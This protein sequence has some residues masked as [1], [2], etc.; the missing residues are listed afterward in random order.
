MHSM[1]RGLL[2][3]ALLSVA[4][5]MP[6]AGDAQV[7]DTVTVR[8]HDHDMALFISGSADDVVVLEA[9]GGSSHRV[10][11]GVVPGLSAFAR[12][13]AYDR[14]GYGLSAACDSPRTA[15]RIVREL[16]EALRAAG[17]PGPYLLAGW[18]LGGSIVRVFAGNFPEEVRGLVL[19]DPAPED[20]YARAAGAY[21]DMWSAEE[22][23]YVPA[24]FAD[25]S[26]RAEQREFAAYSASMEQARASDARHA[27]PTVLLIAG[28][29]AEGPP[30]PISA[31]WIEELSLWGSRRPNLRV[32]RVPGV[33]HH[34]AR[35]R[36]AAVIAAVREL[37]ND[38]R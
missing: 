20:F 7:I 10:W 3:R 30:D 28:R 11:N 2:R 6:S 38:N 18:S 5:L 8:V 32:E 9:G 31:I 21:P 19:V 29:D 34:I 14:P 13:V 37:L 35:E 36:P 4:L 22:E 17:V 12:V 15:D 24:L 25:S 23:A 16:R 1:L 33:G 26:R 27:T